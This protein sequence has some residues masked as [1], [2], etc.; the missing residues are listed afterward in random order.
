MFPWGNEFDGMRLNYCDVNC[1]LETRATEYDDGY[2]LTAPVRSHP[3]GASWCD[4][5]DMAGN[6][7]EWVVDWYDS[8][9]YGHSPSRN[10]IGPSSGEDR[11]LRGGTWHSTQ[12]YVRTASREHYKPGTRTSEAGFRCAGLL[13][14]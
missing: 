8:D 3:S 13:G 10:P 11:V 5:L 6:V 7:W 2:A 4:A 9:Y 1:P 12:E 14:E